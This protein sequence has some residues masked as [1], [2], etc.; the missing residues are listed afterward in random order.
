MALLKSF[1]RGCK[2]ET[3]SPP[4]KKKSENGF[5]DQNCLVD[6]FVIKT[7]DA[8][9]YAKHLSVAVRGKDEIY[10]KFISVFNILKKKAL[11][12]CVTKVTE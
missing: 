3:S 8:H 1:V 10:S 2:S 5:S 4:L 7:A 6:V 9:C 11:M 12:L